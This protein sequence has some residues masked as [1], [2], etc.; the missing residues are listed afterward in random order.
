MPEADDEILRLCVFCNGVKINRGGLNA[1]HPNLAPR[2][3]FH[4]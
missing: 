3:A 1:F 4:K 2:D